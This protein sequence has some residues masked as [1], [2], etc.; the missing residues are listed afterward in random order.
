MNQHTIITVSRQYGSGGRE[1][2]EILEKKTGLRLY[3]RQIICL[4][5][6][7]IGAENMDMN[8]LN[9]LKYDTV[10]ANY[11][12]YG[13]IGSTGIVTSSQMFLAQ[14]KVIR[15]LAENGGIF[16]GGCSDFVLQDMADVH[17][18]F[19]CADDGFRAERGEKCYQGMTLDKLKKEDKKRA[20][21]YNY[22]T[23]QTWGDPVC[24]DVVLNTGR[25]SLEKAADMMLGYIR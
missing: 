1:I 6:E 2:C 8:A 20:S 17:S 22:Y 12:P 24:Y 14:A 11:S 19:I 3:D 10:Y 23:G 5:G 25:M 7:Q 15:K 9:E 18:F 21:H 16:L 13:S 4:A